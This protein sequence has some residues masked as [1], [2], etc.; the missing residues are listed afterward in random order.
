[1]NKIVTIDK[2]KIKELNLKK[3]EV[4]VYTLIDLVGGSYTAR[5]MCGILGLGFQLHQVEKYCKTLIDK[6]L[7]KENGDKFV[8]S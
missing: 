4:L 8:L 1:M 6:K 3:R 5:E 7:I 2:E